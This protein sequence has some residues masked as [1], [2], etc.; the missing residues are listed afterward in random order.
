MEIESESRAQN[1]R[2]ELV[3]QWHRAC[4]NTAEESERRHGNFVV[5][6]VLLNG[7]GKGFHRDGRARVLETACWG[8]AIPFVEC[9]VL[10]EMTDETISHLERREVEDVVFET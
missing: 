8:N 5:T 3:A 9:M 4:T 1:K 7:Q 6:Q 10:D 2:V